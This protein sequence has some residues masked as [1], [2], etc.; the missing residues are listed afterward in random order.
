M[1][2]LDFLIVY[3]S[4]HPKIRVGSIND[5]GYV[6]CD[7]IEYDLL[8]S[9]GLANDINFEVEF[10]NKYSCQC[11]AYDGTIDSL[12][13]SDDRIHFI[14]KNISAV[15]NE[16]TTNMLDIINNN[17]NIF[18]KMDI[19]TWEYDWIKTLSIPE[20]NKFKQIVIEFHFPF[21]YSEDIFNSFSYPLAVE[22]KINCL[23]K[24]ADTHYLVHLHGNNCC[25][26][27]VYNEIVV[28]NVF[29]CTYIRKDLCTH[30]SRNSTKIPSE[31]DSVNVL[32]N[33]DIKLEGYPFT[34]T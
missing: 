27:T 12:S 9:C 2:N 11:Y 6:I 5:G 33:E 1:E 28:P 15:E 4:E 25:G 7:N 20:L 30:L 23:K 32:G 18:L 13:N 8:L 17:D 21:T 26:T 10:I 14:K 19:E 29:E 34:C 31:L 3:N 16:K 24:F 22:D